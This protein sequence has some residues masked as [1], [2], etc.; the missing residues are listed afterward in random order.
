MCLFTNPL[1]WNITSFK[2]SIW[3]EIY[4]AHNHIYQFQ[5]S[6]LSLCVHVIFVL[7]RLTLSHIAYWYQMCCY[8]H[9]KISPDIDLHLNPMVCHYINNWVQPVSLKHLTAFVMV[10]KLGCGAG[11]KWTKHS[12]AACVHFIGIHSR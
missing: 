9:S 10:S 6:N 8:A 2:Q 3:Y 5:Q 12:H 11:G 7:H 1:R 4:I